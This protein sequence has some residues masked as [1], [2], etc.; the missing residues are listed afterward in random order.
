[1]DRPLESSLATAYLDARVY[2]VYDG[3]PAL[4]YGCFAENYHGFDER[5]DLASLQRTTEVIALFIA[6]WCGLETIEE[7]I[8]N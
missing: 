1:M 6:E 4:N 2:A 8:S 5:V 3:I 7:S